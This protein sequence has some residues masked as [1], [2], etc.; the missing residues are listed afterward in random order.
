[1]ENK[2]L[3]ESHDRIIMDLTA[4][5]EDALKQEQCAREDAKLTETTYQVRKCVD[6]VYFLIINSN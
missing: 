4:V 1:M 3:K 6:Y 2:A 5:H